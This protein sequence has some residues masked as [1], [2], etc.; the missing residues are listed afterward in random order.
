MTAVVAILATCYETILNKVSSICPCSWKGVLLIIFILIEKVK[1]CSRLQAAVEQ[2]LERHDLLI[3]NEK[4][5]I[6]I[7]DWLERYKQY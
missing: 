5:F 7:K 4:D 6:K 3:D 2:R 1:Y